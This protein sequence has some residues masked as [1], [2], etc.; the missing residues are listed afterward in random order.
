MSTQPLSDPYATIA[1]PLDDPYAS[2]AKPTEQPGMLK[3]IQ[4]SFDTNTATNPKEPLLQT[5]L[6][7]VAGAI[8]APFVHPI[9]TA[10]SLGKS[11]LTMGLSGGYDM[12]KGIASDYKQGGLP[13]AATKLAGNTFGGVALGSAIGAVPEAA[14]GARDMAIGDPNAAALRGLQVGPK[15]P[16]TLSTL[17]SAEGAR[18]YLQGAKNLED[19]QSKIQPAKNEI[20]SEYNKAVNGIGERPV[21]GPD[22]MTTVKDLESERLQLSALNRGLKQQLP[23]AIQ[24]AQQKGMTQAQLLA[25]E[26]AVQSALDPELASTGID[27]KAIRRTFGDVAQVGQRVSGKSTLIEKPQPTGL[28][29]IANLSIQH[30][31]QA[32]GEILGGMRDI[33]AGRGLFSSKP[34]DLGIREGFRTAGPK[35]NL[36]QYQPPTNAGLLNPPSIQLG[37]APEVDGTPEGY[38]P[39]PFYHDTDAMRT[40]RLLKAPP[41]QLGGNVERTPSPP[42]HADTTPMRTGRL[43]NAPEPQPIQLHGNAEGP[44]G[45]P[46]RYDTTPMRQ[47]HILPPPSQDIPLSSH[48]DIFPEQRPG[49]T[50]IRTKL[51]EGKK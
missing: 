4:N 44:K 2:I 32:P 8:G 20:F 26:K 21:K 39:P 34:T 15:S 10:K 17:N 41:I 27:P 18:P 16:K 1:K 38:Q 9:D 31:L 49:S 48:A 37:R 40:G 42:F 7:S 35:P 5:G 23:E 19:I 12:G 11:A 24:L 13:Y 29:R 47:G 50:R 43:L 33:V 30:P 36:G 45:Q 51:I 14:A 3:S 25:R 28:G 46:F 22:G 6:K